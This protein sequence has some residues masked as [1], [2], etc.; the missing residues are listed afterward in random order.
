MLNNN[1]SAIILGAGKDLEKK[2]S[3]DYLTPI[4]LIEDQFGESVLKWT[5]NSLTSNKIDKIRFVGGYEIEKIGREF[6]NLE[7][8]YNALWDKTGVLESL[9]HARKFLNGPVL[10]S[11]GDIVYTKDVVNNLINYQSAGISIAYEKKKYKNESSSKKVIKKNIVSVK[12]DQLMDIGFL[13]ANSSMSGEFIGLAFFNKDAESFIRDFFE[14]DYLEL[15]DKNFQQSKNIQDGYLTDLL[16]YI[17]LNKIKINCVDIK[18][19]WREINDHRSL[20]KFVIGT[21][22]ET[23]SRLKTV[24]KKSKLCDQFTFNIGQWEKN[25]KGIINSLI[26]TFSNTKIAIRSSS[27]FED[28]FSKS[29][30]GAFQSVLNIDLKNKKLVEKSINKVIASYS[31]A[32]KVSD[33]HQVLIQNMVYDVYMSG[34]VFTKDMETGAPYY[35]ISY[36]NTTSRTDTVTSGSGVDIKTLMIN[37]SINLSEIPIEFLSLIQ[38]V[39]EIED[40]TG[41]E[42]LDIEFAI[43]NQNEIYILQVRPIVSLTDKLIVSN[44]E[45][46]LNNLSIYLNKK[47]SPT[48]NMFGKSTIYA[49]M[50]DWNPAEMI[51]SQPKPLAYSMYDYLITE[52]AWRLARE[53][54]GYYNPK[55]A[56]LM[57]NLLGHPFID[58]RASFNNLT[59]ATLPS[60]LFEKLINYYLDV[61]KKNPDKHDKVEFEILFTCLDFSFHEKS[62][63]L[64]QNGFSS[65]EINLIKTSLFELTNNIVSGSVSPINKV[66]KMFE[67]GAEM[68]HL[69]PHCPPLM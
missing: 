30:A 28:S 37:K 48:H 21:K 4:S 69:R 31:T 42:S 52:K 58:V 64:K 5:L 20:V 59:P 67:L 9:Y 26:K 44:N 11:Y 29:N 68:V 16:R 38:S 50:P 46:S 53:S 66:K 32:D 40:A 17:L 25:K 60:K 19:N 43:N 57:T 65:N 34:V 27:F 49:D 24:L 36:D 14:N 45:K 3:K 61:F 62:K 35:V 15:R 6:P 18:N 8:V 23:L 33:E 39:K 55:S 54:I 13:P 51:G 2:N 63:S 7:F 41:Y 22:S 47:F 56:K 12:D 1:I 10:I